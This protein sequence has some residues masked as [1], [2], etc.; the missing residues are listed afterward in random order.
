MG[1]LTREKLTGKSQFEEK[2]PLLYWADAITIAL[3]VYYKKGTY[4]YTIQIKNK[5]KNGPGEG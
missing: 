3:E 5:Q 2:N 4:I 1:G